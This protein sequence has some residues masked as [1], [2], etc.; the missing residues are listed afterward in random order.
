MVCYGFLTQNVSALGKPASYALGNILRNFISKY[1]VNPAC[2]L[3]L[4]A[5]HIVIY[6]LLYTYDKLFHLAGYWFSYST[7]CYYVP[8]LGLL[9]QVL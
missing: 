1:A 4:A 7:T 3:V 2:C 9:T 8:C 6:L 5:I